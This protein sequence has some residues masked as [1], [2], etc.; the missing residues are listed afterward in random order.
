MLLKLQRDNLLRQ[1]RRLVRQIEELTY[2]IQ[3]E[4]ERFP[5]ASLANV[6]PDMSPTDAVS[7]DVSEDSPAAPVLDVVEATRSTL[8]PRFA[9]DMIGQA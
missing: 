5:D 3:R 9:Q 6:S 1:N 2:R 7:A 4:L 8:I